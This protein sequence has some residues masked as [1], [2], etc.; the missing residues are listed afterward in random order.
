VVLLLLLV[1]VTG[2]Q[3]WIAQRAVT[4]LASKLHTKVSLKHIHIDFANHILIQG[5]YIE[6]QHGDT[7]LYAGEA[8][9]KASDWFYLKKEKPVITYLGLHHAYGHLIRRATSNEWNYQFVIDAFNTGKKDKTPGKNEFEMDLKHL[10]LQD[11]R[12]HSDDAWAGSDMDIDAGSVNLEGKE[13]DLKKRVIDLDL[14]DIRNTIVAMRDYKGGK[15]PSSKKI[16]AGIIDT[17][18]FNTGGWAV[19]IKD[20]GLKGCG[21]SFTSSAS[22]APAKM[23]DAA[24]LGISGADIEAYNLRISGDTLRTH[25]AH[26]AA[27]ERCGLTIRELQGDVT[28]SPNVSEIENMLLK[29]DKSVIRRRYVMRYARFPSFLDYIE[30]VRME[31][32]L[33]DAIID[34]HDVAYFAPVFLEYF[35][36]MM[37]VAG[38]FGGT[39]ADF[40]LSNAHYGDAGAAVV[41]N[42]SMKGLPDI[43]H[44]LITFSNGAVI[45]SGKELFRF[46]PMLRNNPN[47]DPAQLTRIIYTG[48]FSGYIDNFAA[49]GTLNTNL[50]TIAASSKLAMPQFQMARAAYSSDITAT[51]FQ[52]G[53][54]LHQPTL[55][56]ITFKGSISGSSFEAEHASVNVNAFISKLGLYGYNYSNITA[57]GVLSRKKFEGKILVD[58]PNL[59]MSF[60][61]NAD[62]SGKEP[63]VKATAHLLQSNLQALHLSA[64]PIEASADFDVDATGNTIDDFLGRALLNNINI[65]RAGHRLDIDSVYMES[66]LAA[67]GSK[68][69]HIESNDFSGVV[70]GK[71]QL[72]Q[73]PYSTQYF[74]GQYLPS[75]IPPPKKYAPNQDLSFS[76]TTKN[77]DSLLL[78]LAP[79]VKGFDNTTVS[80][81]LNTGLQQLTLN[82]KVPYGA[83]GKTRITGLTLKGDGDFRRMKISGDA[84]ELIVGDTLL[85]LT[86]NLATT[87]SNDSVSF[88]ITTSSPDVYGTATLNGAAVARGD[89]IVLSMAPSEFFLNQARW[90]LMGGSQVV[91]RS[92][93][94][95]V[96]NLF[97][98]SGLQEVTVRSEDEYTQQALVVNAANLDLALLTGL[99]RLNGYAPDGRVNG[100]IRITDLFRAPSVAASLHATGVKLGADTIGEVVI[101]GAYN[102]SKNAVSLEKGS[103]I[104]RGQSA[105]TASGTVTFD[106]TSNQHLNGIIALHNAPLSWLDPVLAGYVSRLSGSVNGQVKISGTGIDPDVEGHITL[107]KAAL[108]VDYLGTYYTIP[109][110]TIGISNTEITFNDIPLHDVNGNDATLAGKITHNRFKG[111]QLDLNMKSDE[112][113][114]L[115]LQDYENTVFYGHLVARVKSF[116]VKGLLNDVR[117]S[118]NVAPADLSHLYLPV[119]SSSDI[120]TY[121]YVTFKK[122]GEKQVFNT[123]PKS[124]L[125]IY[126]DAQ[127]NPL[128]E[129]SL[130]LDPTTGDA[131]N[132]RGNGHLRLEVQPSGDLRMYDHFNIEE[133]D[134]TFTFRQLFFKR[135]FTLQSGS[136]VKFSGPIAQ[137]TMD[138]QAT[139]RTRASLYDLLTE[140]EKNGSFIPANEMAD[141]KRQQDVDVLL[142]M[143]GNILR[144]DLKFKLSLPE[145]RSVGTYAYTKFERLN[146]NERELF[147]QVASLLL[148][149]FFIPPESGIGS[150]GTAAIGA[151]NNLSEVLSTNTSA[152][153]TNIV[154]KL[155]GDPKLSVDLKYKNYNVSDNSSGSSLNRNEVKLGLRKNLLNDRVILEVGSAYDWGRPVSTATTSSNFNLLNDFR[156]QLLLSKDGRFRLNGF[157]TTDYDVLTTAN[158]GNVTRSGIGI[159]WR[160]TFDSFAE[161]FKSPKAFA[162]AQKRMLEEQQKVDSN[163]IKKTIGTE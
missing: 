8:E 38:E 56:G 135:Q 3:N 152:Q 44:T 60:D 131:I 21:Y 27:K 122:Y 97:L 148:I 113:E 120:G 147:N 103:G 46:A 146:A 121:T 58:D 128:A 124:K 15:P 123:A 24:H 107:D 80:G 72:S 126:I 127:I 28:V 41:G 17:T 130:I 161:F 75:Y 18:A 100:S 111:L 142:T 9:L 5:L 94:L 48:S 137:T 54:L 86:M 115:N 133:G 109:S 93:Y 32:D 22:P 140:Q 33:Q 55:G 154:N 91:Y 104:F 78:V 64:E 110:A 144:P 63:V 114:V 52:L 159:S 163:T 62:L 81:S 157:R 101:I 90:E 40:R 145:K 31:A 35:P 141:I 66:A 98:K 61:G 158:N 88:N 71:Y 10:D 53:R 59:A 129:I 96:H 92:N 143:R 19:H 89:S 4:M 36:S 16:V 7:L 65:R 67:D 45:T 102:G 13:I 85:R 1:N 43:Y 57:N 84:A 26:L 160:K 106:S 153:L 12:F 70:E 34:P 151:I 6:D 30:K 20:L 82:A 162:R 134:Y 112:F 99:A 14:V 132:A 49:N 119:A 118:I 39:V 87:V 73:L 37:K 139:Y 29:T 76:I 51:D 79:A 150:G 125:T 108:R 77:I 83:I 74:I 47:F 156:I 95:S 149:G 23:F 68:M 25:V 42:I 136:V 69:L 50:G 138:V 11:V 155:L 116:T 2:V 117:M 105:L